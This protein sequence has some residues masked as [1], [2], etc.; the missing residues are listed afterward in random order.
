MLLY[1]GTPG[2]FAPK[3]AEEGLKSDSG[4]SRFGG[5]HGV[6]TT[7][8]PRVAREFGNAIFVMD[9]RDL[10]RA[11]FDLTPFR[12]PTAPDEKEV[13]VSK[14]S[15]TV[16]PPSLF[17]ELRLPGALQRELRWWQEQD[18]GFP[19]VKAAAPDLAKL[20]PRRREAYG[21]AD[22]R[23]EIAEVLRAAARRISASSPQRMVQ[24]MQ[25]LQEEL[26]VDPDP[27]K[28]KQAV[29]VM[30][31][32]LMKHTIDMIDDPDFQFGN[33]GLKVLETYTGD[34]DFNDPGDVP[35]ID[36][37]FNAEVSYPGLT[38]ISTVSSLPLSDFVSDLIRLLGKIWKV[39]LD[40]REAEKAIMKVIQGSKREFES[41]MKSVLSPVMKREMKEPTHA[42]I[43]F[44]ESFPDP[45]HDFSL[46]AENLEGLYATWEELDTTKVEVTA[47]TIE[48]QKISISHYA[49]VESIL[50]DVGNDWKI[51]PN[52]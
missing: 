47:V 44:Y 12:H 20:L 29:K 8:D 19:V 39:R 5:Q 42:E 46:W 45:Y 24:V 33:D 18:V 51:V 25:Q 2:P 36:N 7:T 40:R 52:F 30:G 34:Y 35:W 37:S 50:E 9:A 32:L 23:Q 48:R 41:W 31:Q 14:G 16:I 10:K 4:Y 27:S 21:P 3:I 1:H 38:R 49:E 43:F 11:G 26:G 17:K 13:R 15:K 6:S 22:V 28:A